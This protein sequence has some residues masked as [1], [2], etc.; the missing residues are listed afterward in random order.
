MTTE[1]RDHGPAFADP[2]V[3]RQQAG[4]DG[5]WRDTWWRT[6]FLRFVLDRWGASSATSMLDV[7]CGAGHW[8]RG[9]LRAL[10]ECQRLAGIDIEPSFA[11][12]AS[13]RAAAVG[14]GDRCEY[15]QGR[16]E[17]IPWPDDSFDI[18][19]C[20]TVLI[21]V[22]DVPVALAEMLRV[23]RPGGFLIAAEPDNLAS[24]LSILNLHPR[25][26]AEQ[27]MAILQLQMTCEAGKVALGEGDSS[28]GGRLPG[29]FREAG[30]EAVE[31]S[32]N[33]SCAVLY[34]PYRRGIQPIQLA[35]ELSF[36]RAGAALFT[37]GRPDSLRWFRAGGGDDAGFAALWAHV[38][39]Y[40]RDFQAQVAAG[41]L[42]G[43]R[44][45]T[46]YLIGGRKTLA[47]G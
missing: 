28:I 34:P 17:A 14:I 18:V 24:S 16:A 12:L 22:P 11:E 13:E 6:D 30:L 10:P 9:L 47:P 42:H 31:V 23:L 27:T 41:E 32:M 15:R 26:S 21:H 19:T 40:L 1:D 4:F 8:G 2:E 20:Q 29:L 36:A 38:E 3:Y 7:G 45:H 25:P 37:G 39:A 5:D 35:A 43:A 33:E 44:G 46:F